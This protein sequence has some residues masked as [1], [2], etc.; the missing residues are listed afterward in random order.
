MTWSG[1]VPQYARYGVGNGE[2][3]GKVAEVTGMDTP[4]GYPAKYLE[5][6]SDADVFNP[7]MVHSTDELIAWQ[8]RHGIEMEPEALEVFQ[9]YLDRNYPIFTSLVSHPAVDEPADYIACSLVLQRGVI[10]YNGNGR[11]ELFLRSYFH[12]AKADG[13]EYVNFVP[14]RGIHY[15]FKSDALWFP[16]ELTRLM[17]EPASYVEIDIATTDGLDQLDIPAQFSP[18]TTGF[19]TLNGHKYEVM[20]ISARFEVSKR[21]RIEDLIIPFH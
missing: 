16:L 2:I 21:Q 14:R 11:Q 3:F 18:T 5:N 7:G 15:S 6:L 9:G 13:S 20:R 4:Q 17:S 1:P 19:A 8:R 10:V 12:S